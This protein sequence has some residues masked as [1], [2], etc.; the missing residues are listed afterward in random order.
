MDAV[1]GGYWMRLAEQVV[2]WGNRM[3]IQSRK[4]REMKYFI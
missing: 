1:V 4:W 2:N 3:I